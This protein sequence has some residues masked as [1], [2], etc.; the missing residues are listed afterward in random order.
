MNRR[1]FKSTQWVALFALG[2]LALGGLDATAAQAADPSAIAAGKAAF[3]Y[4]CAAC[5][6]RERV[7]GGQMLPA[8]AS[9]ALKYKGAVP[10]ALEDRRDLTPAFVEYTV[11]H[12]VAVMPFFRKTMVSDADLDA[13]AAYLTRNNAPASAAAAAKSTAG[14]AGK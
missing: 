2:G 7:A 6:G 12:G 5:H 9:L 8:T 4:H 3:E 14:T 11:R 13:I 1:T 10:A